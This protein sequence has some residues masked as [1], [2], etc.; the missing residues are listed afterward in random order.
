MDG[1]QEV[2]AD[3]KEILHG[4]GHREKPLRVRG[5]KQTSVGS[6]KLRSARRCY[7]Y[8]ALTMRHR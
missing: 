8:Q 3:P 2:A 5:L 4:A 7:V 1:S 6:R